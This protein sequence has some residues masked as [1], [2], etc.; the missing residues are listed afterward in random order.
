MTDSTPAVSEALEHLQAAVHCATGEGV[1]APFDCIGMIADH[2]A[3]LTRQL[4]EAQAD[5]DELLRDI[6]TT[7]DCLVQRAETAEAA[8]AD[9]RRDAERFGV[10][11]RSPDFVWAGRKWPML[12]HDALRAFIDL[13]IGAIREENSDAAMSGGTGGG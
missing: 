4:A 13:A 9:A 8:L 7:T 12:D 2:I 3:D 5:R 1:Q 11:I 6:R 10:V